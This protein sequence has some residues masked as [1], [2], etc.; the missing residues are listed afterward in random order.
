MGEKERYIGK[1]GSRE[2]VKSLFIHLT[3]EKGLQSRFTLKPKSFQTKTQA[4]YQ[5]SYSV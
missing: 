3:R 4:Y 5:R 1:D 2:H